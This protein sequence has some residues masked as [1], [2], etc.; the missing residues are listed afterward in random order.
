VYAVEQ[1]SPFSGLSTLSYFLSLETK[2]LTEPH[3]SEEEGFHVSDFLSELVILSILTI[4][5]CSD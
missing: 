4:P 2:I 5:R 1:D 3:V